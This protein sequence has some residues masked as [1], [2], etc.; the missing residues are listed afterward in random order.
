MKK[1]V[2][3]LAAGAVLTAVTPAVAQ[4]VQQYLLVAP[5]YPVVLQGERYASEE[6]PALNYNGS[7]YLP[8]SALAEAG[9]AEVRWEENAQQVEVTAAGRQ[10]EHANTAFRVMEVSGKNGKYTVKGQARVFEGVMHYAVSDGHDYLLDRHRQLE[11]GAPA[12]ASFELQL[13]IPA[14]KLPGNGTLMLELYEE[15]G[16]DGSRVHELAVPLEQFR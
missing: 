8:V 2:L 3:G 12:W 7:T 16:K 15:S 13:D 11:G 4:T 6:L 5:T 10:P 1:F 14:D 9:I